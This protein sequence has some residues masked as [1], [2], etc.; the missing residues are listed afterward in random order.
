MAAP[1]IVYPVRPG[2]T[3]Q[4]LRYSLRSLANLPHGRVWIAGHMPP[5]V[6]HAGHIPVEPQATKYKGS[7]AN[8]RAAVEHE[9]VSE[10]FLYFNDDFFLMRPLVSMPVLHRGP[11]D[12]VER[13]Y[14]HRPNGSY[15]RGLRETR[16]L[17][18]EL[19][20]RQPLSYELHVPMPMTKARV[21]ETLEVGAHLEVLHKRTLYGNLHQVGGR[22]IS[23][24]KILTRSP[25]FPQSAPFLSTSPDTF[26]HGLVGRFIRAAFPVPGPYEKDRGR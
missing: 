20:H 16:E 24:P 19:G 2:N 25:Q 22:E 26:A 10:E 11:L 4:E 7:T 17:L 12:R 18:G 1:D 23:D 21:R 3:N 13:Y 5:W 8:L 9:E 6:R 15:L 14:A